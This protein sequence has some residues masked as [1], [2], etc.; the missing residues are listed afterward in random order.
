MCVT[1]ADIGI[2]VKIHTATQTYINTYTLLRTERER[3]H[4]YTN[5][6]TY[7]QSMLE[8]RLFHSISLHL[9]S[10][11]CMLCVCVCML[12]VCVVLLCVCVVSCVCV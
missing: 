10:C 2:D 1:Y 12:C 9:S 5:T 8:R 4:T 11:V 3:A 6:H 7:P